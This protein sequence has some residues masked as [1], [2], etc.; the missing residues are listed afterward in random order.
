MINN[1][2]GKRIKLNKQRAGVPWVQIPPPAILI[3]NRR[4]PY[5][6][7]K[8]LDV[9]AEREDFLAYNPYDHF[10]IVKY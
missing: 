6:F 5:F 8:E 1:E 7:I 4:K 9:E 3:L 10:H 2:V